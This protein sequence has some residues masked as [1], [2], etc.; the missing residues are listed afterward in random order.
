MKNLRYIVLVFAFSLFVLPSVQAQDFSR[1]SERTIMGTARYVGMGGAMT[2]IGGDASAAHDNPAG[3]GLYRRSETMLTT[4]VAIDHAIQKGTVVPRRTQWMLPQASVVVS[5]PTYDV[6]G[7]Q[8]HNIMFSYRRLNS[9]ARRMEAVGTDGAS[10]GALLNTPSVPMDIPFCSDRKNVSNH[11]SLNEGGYVNEFAFMYAMNISD[12][13]YAGVG[14]EIQSYLLQSDATYYETFNTFNAAGKPF[15]IQNETSLVFRGAS[16]DLS[17]GMIYRP[18]GWLRLGLSFQT[19]TVGH[20]HTYTRGTFRAMTDSLRYSYAPDLAYT[21][22]G[23]HMPLRTSASVA[24]QFGAYGMVGLQYDYA[25]ANFQNDI[26]TLRAGLEVIPVL[27]MY[28]NAGYVYESTFKEP[29][30]T[31]MVADFSRQDTYFIQPRSTQYVSGAIGYRG[32]YTMVQ[33]AY[34]YRWQKINFYAHE[35]ADPYLINADTHRIVITLGWHRN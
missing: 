31:P 1:L 12:Q 9:Y 34:Q 4:D 35:A 15:D 16:C 13:W 17:L 18:T 27:G 2:A 21:D 19:P 5:L 23:F 11:L 6:S 29:R 20:V 24:F 33:V 8:F 28:I 14:L 10:L 7:I 30:I 3:L 25:H 26:H 22:R 32:A